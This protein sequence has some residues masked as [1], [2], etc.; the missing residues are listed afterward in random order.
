MHTMNQDKD[1]QIFAKSH[2]NGSRNLIKIIIQL[3][4]RLRKLIK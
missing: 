4:L 1:L 2:I 3:F